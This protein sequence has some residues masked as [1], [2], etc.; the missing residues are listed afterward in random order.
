VLERQ[1]AGNVPGGGGGLNSTAGSAAHSPF[2]APISD[3]FGMTF[4]WVVGSTLLAL[5]PALLL[6]RRGATTP[7]A[8]AEGGAT[9]DETPAVVT[10]TAVDE[11]TDG[12]PL[13]GAADRG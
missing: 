8:R 1:I 2:A 11:L 3:A 7:A 13:A 10:A 12:M 5:V 4:W 6:P 9:P